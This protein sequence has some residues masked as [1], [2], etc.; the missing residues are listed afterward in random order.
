MCLKVTLKPCSGISTTQATTFT[1]DATKP[2]RTI[3]VILHFISTLFFYTR[4]FPVFVA[5]EEQRV[6]EECKPT[7]AKSAT[8][9]PST[10]FF[11]RKLSLL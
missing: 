10:V 4:L 1:I 7:S 5:L 2:G 6:T 11:T 9:A 3:K 8:R